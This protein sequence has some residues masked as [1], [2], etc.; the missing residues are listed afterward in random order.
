MTAIRIKISAGTCW[1]THKIIPAGPVP[2]NVCPEKG[3]KIRATRIKG[4]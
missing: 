1:M 4:H 2:I 3:N